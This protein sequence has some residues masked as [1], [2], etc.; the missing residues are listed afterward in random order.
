[1]DA[2]IVT[3]SVYARFGSKKQNGLLFSKKTA[4]LIHE[5]FFHDAS[6]RRHDPDQVQRVSSQAVSRHPCNE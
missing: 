4:R 5:T 3:P 2:M 6:L 1:M